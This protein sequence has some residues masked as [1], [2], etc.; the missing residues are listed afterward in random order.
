MQVQGIGLSEEPEE[1]DGAAAAYDVTPIPCSINTFG[2][3]DDHDDKLLKRIAE[4]T[5]G[6]YYYVKDASMIETLFADCIGGLL[7]TALQDAVLSLRAADGVEIVKVYGKYPQKRDEETGVVTVSLGEMQFEEKRDI[8]L[9]LRVPALPGPVDA[10]KILAVRLDGVD[11][12]T[13]VVLECHA[14]AS[15]GRPERASSFVE[16]RAVSTQY[17]RL[18]AAHAMEDASKEADKGDLEKARELIKAAI[19]MIEA[20]PSKDEDFCK[21]LVKDLQE[22]LAGM[23]SQREY[24]SEGGRY[25]STN[26]VSHFNQRSTNFEYAA[27]SEYQTSSRTKMR[28]KFMS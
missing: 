7:S 21:N 25:M 19:E 11:V 27:Q 9:A 5:R 20:S 23:R 26:V 16:N 4:H 17:N 28:S 8:V 1:D 6:M 2:Y 15:I 3:G 13:E 12:L 18:A 22:C 10:Q 14:A 24:E